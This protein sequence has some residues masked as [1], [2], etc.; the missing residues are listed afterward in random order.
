[1]DETQI[2]PLTDDDLNTLVRGPLPGA[3]K[4]HPATGWMSVEKIPGS[5]ILPLLDPEEE[6]PQVVQMGPMQ[7]TMEPLPQ[8]Q[9]VGIIAAKVVEVGKFPNGQE[10][11]FDWGT[12]DTIYMAS[13]RGIDIGDYTIVMIDKVIGYTKADEE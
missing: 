9:R 12:G 2:R 3:L 7:M 13:D 10:L 11:E 6:K 8:N 5:L 1:M 4:P